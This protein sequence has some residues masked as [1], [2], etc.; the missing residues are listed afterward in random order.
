MLVSMMLPFQVIM[1][2]QYLWFKVLG[3]TNSFKPL[4]VPYFFGQGFFIY[5]IMNFID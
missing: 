3:W 4:I 5:M 2:P 1:I